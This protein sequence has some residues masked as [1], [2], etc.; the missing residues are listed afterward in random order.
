MA[1]D[2]RASKMVEWPRDRGRNGATRCPVLFLCP[3]RP[4]WAGAG[5]RDSGDTEKLD[6]AIR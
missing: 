1:P 3:P 6:S 5:L 4:L 2:V